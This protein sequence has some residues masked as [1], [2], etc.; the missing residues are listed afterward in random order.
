MTAAKDW[1]EIHAVDSQR[2]ELRD[3]TPR[4]GRYWY[5]TTTTACPVCAGG[6]VIRQRRHTPRPDDPQ[7]RFEYIERY[8]YCLR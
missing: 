6:H 7:E 1:G 3:Q 4:R 2:R 8:D 5:F